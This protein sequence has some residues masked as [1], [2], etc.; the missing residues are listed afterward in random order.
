MAAS[1]RTPEFRGDEH[2]RVPRLSEGKSTSHWT[3]K[4]EVSSIV[5]LAYG[6]IGGLVV[7]SSC[8]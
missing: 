4:D 7:G 1:L 5:L 3:Q 8:V 6:A 2:Y